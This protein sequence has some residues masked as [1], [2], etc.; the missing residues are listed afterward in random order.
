MNLVIVSGPEATGKTA[1]G[2]AVARLLG[3]RH[4]TK[5]TIKE[6]L[7]DVR[8]RSTWHHAWY[9]EQAKS[10]FFSEIE[11]FIDRKQSV[12]IESNFI[13]EDRQRLADCLNAGVVIT[14][15][16]CTARGL[17]SFK[18]FVKRNETGNR[19]SG[20]HDRRLY[21]LVFFQ[22]LFRYFTRWPYKPLGLT[23]KLLVVDTTDF[24]RVDYKKIADFVKQT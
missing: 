11:R 7:F 19:H 4:Q 6:A 10:E 18:R 20:H 23:K 13:A 8:P 2:Q 1:I 22:N 9:E 24:S 15:I 17:T 21:G 12:V 14:E 3:Y 16:Y 5:D